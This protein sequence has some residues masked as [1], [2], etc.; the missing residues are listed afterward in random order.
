MDIVEYQF[1][2][3]LSEAS[4]MQG[5][6]KV[7]FPFLAMQLVG[8]WLLTSL[9][10][11]SPQEVGILQHGFATAPKVLT[12]GLH[13]ELPYPLNSIHRVQAFRT[14][15][16]PFGGNSPDKK[17][18]F[19]PD[20]AHPAV[21]L[22]NDNQ[23]NNRLYLIQARQSYPANAGTSLSPSVNMDLLYTDL[24]LYGNIVDPVAYYM[25]QDDPIALLSILANKA[26]T[27]YLLTQNGQNILSLR[28]DGHSEAIKSM[29]QKLVDE[30]KIGVNIFA[31]EVSHLQPPPDVAKVYNELL[32]AMENARRTRSEARQHAFEI[33]TS[34]LSE[35]NAVMRKAE[36]DTAYLI[37][38]AEVEKNN[39]I[40]QQTFYRKY[41]ELYK[42]REAM[43]Y[44]ESWLQNVPKIIVTNEKVREI[45]NFELKTMRPD[46]L[47]FPG[48]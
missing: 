25:R 27:Q 20:S 5:L 2:F 39:Y 12:S 35:A 16:L 40:Q 1:G 7:A 42:T 43:E 48:N 46:L 21:D 8:L 28:I 18:K 37:Q 13:L 36:A 23:Y 26:L 45:I 24:T 14:I 31:V 30:R 32:D 29:I 47:S 9:V 33:N 3:Q 17:Q 22:W 34:A 4:L 15:M 6:K 10:Y 11:I 19:T 44:I 38:A 41:P